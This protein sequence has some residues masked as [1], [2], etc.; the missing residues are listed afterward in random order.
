MLENDNLFPLSLL[1]LKV[2]TIWLPYAADIF[3]KYFNQVVQLD[4]VDCR[5]ILFLVELYVK[6]QTFCCAVLHYCGGARKPSKL[7]QL[8]YK[9][10][11]CM[12][13]KYLNWKQAWLKVSFFEGSQT[14]TNE[15]RVLIEANLIQSKNGWIWVY[16]IYEWPKP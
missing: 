6:R 3:C 14:V 16:I 13:S 12:A 5:S 9:T 15:Q 11:Q 1:L 10:Y 2:E 7:S 8:T 4:N